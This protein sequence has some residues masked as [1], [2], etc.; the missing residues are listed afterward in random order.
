[1]KYKRGIYCLFL[2]MFSA[3]SIFGCVASG[4]YGRLRLAGSDM[5]IDQL[6]KHWEDYHVSY[7][8]VS[9]TQPNAILFDPKGDDKVITL[10]QYWATV[11]DKSELSE[12]IR[13]MGPMSSRVALY[14]IM[15]PG[16]QVF[17]YIYMSNMSPLIRVV[18]EKTLWIGNITLRNIEGAGQN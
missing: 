4:K 17:G 10:H 5:T 15:G 9:V 1:M 14:R 7:A 18:D 16:D 6:V 8:G 13:W 11:K 2:L 3:A 12:I